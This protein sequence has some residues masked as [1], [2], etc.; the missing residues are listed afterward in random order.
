[1]LPATRMTGETSNFAMRNCCGLYARNREMSGSMDGIRRN[2][3]MRYVVKIMPLVCFFLLLCAGCKKTSAPV[4]G[5]EEGGEI[6]LTEIEEGGELIC[7]TLNGPDTYYELRGRGAGLQYMLAESFANSLGLRLRMETARD[8]G[9]MIAILKASKADVVACKISPATIGKNGLSGCAVGDS[10]GSWAVR[11]TSA[12]LRKAL[13]EWYSAEVVRKV[14]SAALAV[15]DNRYIR[16]RVH[17][18]FSSRSKG[19]VSNYDALFVRAGRECGWDW[20]LIASQ[21]Y[22]ESG[23]DAEAVSW[24]GAKGLMQLMPSTASAMGLG[25]DELFDP[26]KNVMAAARYLKQLERKFCEVT[27][28]VERKKFVLAAYN[29]G[30]GHIRDAMALARKYGRNHH[31]WDDTGYFVLHLS[32]PQF[33]KDDAVRCGYMVGRETFGY[34]DDVMRR[35][36]GYRAALHGGMPKVADGYGKETAGRGNRFSGKHHIAGREDSLFRIRR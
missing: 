5:S 16:R 21:C 27:D 18:V 32:E 4:S 23:F 1:M 11:S 34:V 8:T 29:G 20:K 14:Q 13:D 9:G 33:Y 19:V 12:D 3:D 35:W 7:V 15:N 36:N 24:A 17:P 31:L 28:P 10:A 2:A 30:Y 26:E 25:A 22:Q 6:D